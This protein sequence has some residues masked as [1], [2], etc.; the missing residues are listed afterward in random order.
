MLFV[1]PTM[2]AMV[3]AANSKPSCYTGFYKTINPRGHFKYADFLVAQGLAGPNSVITCVLQPY[4]PSGPTEF[5][6]L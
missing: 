3:Y 2:A 1:Q 5:K 4:G 6:T